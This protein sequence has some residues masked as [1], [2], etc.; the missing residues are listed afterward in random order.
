MF[1]CVKYD[2]LIS[3]NDHKYV[4]QRINEIFC[5]ILQQV[6]SLI[7]TL[8]KCTLLQWWCYKKMNFLIGWGLILFPNS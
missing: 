5:G 1:S 7:L 6:C 8:I 2:I 4:L 3:I